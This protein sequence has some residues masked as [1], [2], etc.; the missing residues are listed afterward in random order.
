M[1]CLLLV[2]LLKKVK[3][4]IEGRVEINDV[5]GWTDSE[6]AICWI[7]GKS[8][9]WKSWVENRVVAIRS[10][11]PAASWYHVSSGDNPADIPTRINNLKGIMADGVWLN[12][13]EFLRK[14]NLQLGRFD[15]EG[16]YDK[17][18]V[19]AEAKKYPKETSVTCTIGNAESGLSTVINTTKYSNL[20]KLIMVSGYVIRFIQ[21]LLRKVRNTADGVIYNDKLL[22]LEEYN[23]ARDMWIKEEQSKLHKEKQFE[24]AFNCIRCA[25]CSFAPR[26]RGDTYRNRFIILDTKGKTDCEKYITKMR[27]V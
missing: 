18:D 2:N 8:K 7:K 15:I 19:V 4:S 10:I 1:G 3:S 21:R 6:V 5:I 22:C 25:S 13:P 12:G 27:Y 14:E 17:V 23:Y 11:I 16:R 20:K 24:S 9:C 26:C